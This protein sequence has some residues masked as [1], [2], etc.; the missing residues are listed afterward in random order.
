MLSIAPTFDGARTIPSPEVTDLMLE[1]LQ[2]TPRDKVMEIGTGSGYQT[3]RF[4]DSGAEVHSV[5]LEPWIDTTVLTGG[6][7]YLYHRDGLLGL[8]GISPFTGIVPP[9]GVEQIPPG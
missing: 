2:L 9:C 3:Q 8:P 6:C 5:E 4:A 1:L 7:G